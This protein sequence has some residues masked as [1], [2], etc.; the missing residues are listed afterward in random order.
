MLSIGCGAT[1][2][3]ASL[4]SRIPRYAGGGDGR[5]A[6]TRRSAPARRVAARPTGRR[7][8]GRAASSAPGERRR[9]SMQRLEQLQEAADLAVVEACPDVADVAKLV[10]FVHREHERAEGVRASSFAAR[11]AGDDELVVVLR[12]H[13]QPVA[14]AAAGLVRA[15]DALRHQS[16]EPALLRHLEQRIAVVEALRERDGGDALVEQLAQ[17]R[18]SL[19]ERPS[20]SGR[21]RARAGRTRSRRAGR[22]PAAARRSSCGRRVDAGDLAVDD[23]VRALDRLRDRLR[24]LGE[25]RRQ[26]VA[27][28]REEP[29]L[30]VVH[31]R[32]RAIAV[33]LH[34]ERPALAVRHALGE[35]RE[36]RAIRPLRRCLLVVALD[37]QPVLLLAVEVRRHE[38]PAAAQALAVQHEG[39]LPVGF[40]LEQLLGTAI[41]D[42]D[43]PGAVLA[44]RDLAVEGRVLERVVLDVDGER[45]SARLERNALRHGPRGK[46]AVPFEPEVVVEPAGIVALDDEDRRRLAPRRSE[47]LGR[48][49]RVALPAVLWRL[50]GPFST[51]WFYIARSGTK[52]RSSF[53]T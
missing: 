12:L 20:T 52:P 36:H 33:E 48:L 17:L 11:V 3:A 50:T 40:L 13:L 38:R 4:S 42:L 25:A 39:Q 6:S 26:I 5:R 41:P 45:A 49:L 44:L 14:R 8:C 22:F 9:V 51:P 16:L 34:L 47:R 18:L 30:A 37:Q 35:R 28:P 32:D 21:R 53:S 1:T 19:A 10:S 24:D 23:G 29:A 31:V 43:P 7:P 27:V 46:R 15:V 2:S